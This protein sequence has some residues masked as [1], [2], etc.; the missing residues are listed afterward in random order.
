MNPA[1]RKYLKWLTKKDLYLFTMKIYGAIVMAL[2]LASIAAQYCI[3]WG[4]R[5][6]LGM[7][8]SDPNS[9]QNLFVTFN[10]EVPLV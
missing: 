4:I 6:S 10:T 1:P 2:V 3:P 8:Y 7:Q 9:I 5:L